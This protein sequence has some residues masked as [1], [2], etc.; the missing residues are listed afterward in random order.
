[1]S[2]SRESW[3]SLPPCDVARIKEEAVEAGGEEA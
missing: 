2:P 1:L 3:Y